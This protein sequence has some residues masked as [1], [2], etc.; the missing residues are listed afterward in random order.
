MTEFI[1]PY[2][3]DGQE[4]EG[5]LVRPEG[6]AGPWPGLLL[7]PNWMGVTADAKRRAQTWADWGFVVFVPDLYG[8]DK[9]PRDFAEAASLANP[10]RADPQTTRQRMAKA[11]ALLE[12]EGAKRSI[13]APKLRAAVGYCFGGGNVLELARAGAPLEAVVAFHGDLTTE[14]PAAPGEITAAILALHG[15]LDP[16][17]PKSHR[18]QFEEEMRQA[19]AEWELVVFGGVLHGYTD[20]GVD[21][22]PVS[23][24]D[25]RA[26]GTSYQMARTFI[27]EAF[28]KA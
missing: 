16:V 12:E 7:A 20:V 17:V 9:R 15:S 27:E 1:I 14:R 21:A 8:K 24:Y 19:G 28:V 23:R 13:L 10:L 5:V 6:A 22:P 25:A 4:F 18:D 26:A 11:L 3:I 2:Q